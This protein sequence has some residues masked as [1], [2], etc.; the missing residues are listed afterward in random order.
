MM[1]TVMTMTVMVTLS[2]V[3]LDRTIASQRFARNDQDWNAALSAAQAGLDDYVQRLNNSNGSYYIYN[4]ANPDAANLA[5]GTVSSKPRWAPVPQSVGATRAWFH[6]DVNTNGYT[7]A[8]SAPQNGNIVVTATGKVGTRTRTLSGSVRRSGFMDHMYFTDFET[9][10]PIL[11]DGGSSDGYHDAAW[12]QTNCADKYFDARGSTAARNSGCSKIQFADDT[13]D[14]P[15]HSNDAIL[16]CD[17]ATFRKQVSTAYVASALTSNRTYRTS[18]CSSTSGTTFSPSVNNP[19]TVPVVSMP[20]TNSGLKAL[21][22]SGATPRGCLYVGPTKI[23]LKQGTMYVTSDWTKPSS[24]PAGCALKTWNPI[25]AA[26][27]VYVDDVPSFGTSDPNSWATGSE[28]G[29]PSCPGTGNLLGY[30]INNDTGW[31]YPCKS[32]DVFIEEYQKSSAN[33][34]DG[35]VTVAASHDIYITGNLEYRNG[36]SGQSLLG[37]IANNYIYYWH[38][39]RS[40]SSNTGNGNYPSI[41]SACMVS[42]AH[43]VMTMNYDLG[44]DLGSLTVIGSIAQKYRGVV[45]TSGGTGYSKDYRYDPRL[46]YDAPPHFLEPTSSSFVPTIVQEKAPAY[47]A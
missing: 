34:L 2:L 29:K 8:N 12:A 9:K 38:P 13:L 46:V 42:V 33:A 20:M 26:G 4:T 21:T 47:S 41:V 1:T 39:V 14:G 10:D 25:P 44:S 36:T 27:V 3:V 17:H 15:V 22:A 19:K 40:S 30:P 11:Y 24:L 32:G 35:R 45:G 5:M 18:G 23:Q 28:T 43:S 16:I 37:L 7:G 6:Y 31:T